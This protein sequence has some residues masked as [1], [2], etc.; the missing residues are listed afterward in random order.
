MNQPSE[1][2]LSHPR[3]VYGAPCTV[4][5]R[6]LQGPDTGR[7]SEQVGDEAMQQTQRET[8]P[9]KRKFVSGGKKYPRKDSLQVSSFS[10]KM[11]KHE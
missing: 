10:C 1:A 11:F 2:L 4:S 5:G 7:P 6:H 3:K 8:H 9:V